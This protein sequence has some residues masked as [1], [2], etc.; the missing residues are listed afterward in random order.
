MSTAAQA[1]RRPLPGNVLVASSNPAR[2][3][4]WIQ[5]LHRADW[6]AQEACGG[7]DALWKLESGGCR[8][9]LLD[10]KLADL[11]SQELVG[12]VEARF[13]STDVVLLDS[14]TGRAKLPPELIN[15][16]IYHLLSTCADAPSQTSEPTPAPPAGVRT[17]G[18]MKA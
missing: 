14:E 9:L 15:S 16:P 11:D 17:R 2:R 5:S 13:P 7:A 1:F 3:Q 10:P 6:P 4:Q 12:M 8:L 18:I